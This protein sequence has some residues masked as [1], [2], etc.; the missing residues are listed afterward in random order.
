V[1]Q[2][3][4]NDPVFFISDHF[5][6]NKNIILIITSHVYQSI[7]NLKGRDTLSSKQITARLETFIGSQ[8]SDEAAISNDF[9]YTQL[10][11]RFDN[12]LKE[13]G[14]LI[15]NANDKKQTSIKKTNRHN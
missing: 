6:K 7:E 4:F 11:L 5:S 8:L 12:F 3:I 10:F 14:D 2:L 1:L 15:K 13:V 9:R